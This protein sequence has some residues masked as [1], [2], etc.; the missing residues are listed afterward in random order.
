MIDGLR[1]FADSV[2]LVTGAGSGIGKA[3]SEAL[4]LRGSH[5]VLSDIDLADAEDVARHI[6]ERGGRASASRLDVCSFDEFR[7]LVDATIAQHGRLDYLFNN[8]GIGVL[9]EVADYT[10]ESWDRIL[11]VNLRGVIHGVQCAYPAMLRQGFGHIVNTASMAGLTT[12]GGMAS[13]AT[14]K[15]AVVAL[16]RALRAEAQGRGVRV[17]ALCPGVIRTPLLQGGKHGVFLAPLPEPQQRALALALFER[18]RPMPASALAHKALDRIAR[19]RAIII[20]PGWWRVF[21]WLERASPALM[22]FLA[23]K[24]VEEG[25][26][27][28]RDART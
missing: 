3:L 18:L 15:H 25:R 28:L 8:A 20:V 6:R 13:Y 26:K 16:S 2:S 23:R 14:T 21:W 22:L 7:A 11:G 17:S 9:G 4:A 19:N 12:G 27:R 5:V 10:L 1:T 24:I